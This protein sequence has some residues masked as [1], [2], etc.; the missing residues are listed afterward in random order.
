MVKGNGNGDDERPNF[1]GMSSEQG[2]A[3]HSECLRA[4][5]YAGFEIADTEI[6]VRDIGIRLDAITNNRQGLAFAWEFKGSWQGSRPG[7]RR[8]DS[9]LKMLAQGALLSLSEFGACMPPLFVM[10]SHF[11]N[12]PDVSAMIKGSIRGGWIFEIIDSRDGK[13]LQWLANATE[14]DLR[15]ML[16]KRQLAIP[17][18]EAQ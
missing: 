8:S 15:K 3:F 6:H 13:R 1:Q 9:A 18:A 11:P 4:L 14:G 16:D 10:T 7:L 17:L 5:R 12:T 2:A